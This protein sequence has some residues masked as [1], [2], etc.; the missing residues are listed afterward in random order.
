MWHRGIIRRARQI[1]PGTNGLW[2]KNQSMKKILFAAAIS[3]TFLGCDN[4]QTEKGRNNDV[5]QESV[6]EQVEQPAN[7]ESGTHSS[8]AHEH[9]SPHG[10]IVKAA[11]NYHIEMV[12]DGKSLDFYLLDAKEMPVK[13]T[14]TGT[15]MLQ[16]ENQAAGSKPLIKEGDH[17]TLSLPKDAHDFNAIVTFAIRGTTVTAQFGHSDIP[18][19]HS[20]SEASPQPES[21]ATK[22]TQADKSGTQVKKEPIVTKPVED[23][24]TEQVVSQEPSR[25]DNNGVIKPAG[26]YHI[27]LTPDGRNYDFYLLAPNGKVVS[28][29]VTGTVVFQA[30]DNPA[31]TQPL[32]VDGDHFTFPVRGHYH[33]F[34]ITVNFK[35]GEKTATAIFTDSDV[36]HTH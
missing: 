19:T 31:V 4:G 16:V 2:I 1:I 36:P 33:N 22:K 9:G 27:R 23:K 25:L 35:V 32:Q 30:E 7:D 3:L 20:G 5:E 29:N 10:G 13:E 28:S 6:Q 26:D 12:Q 11:G 21:P 18:H 17:F 8:E 15:A 14:A 24:V 34:S